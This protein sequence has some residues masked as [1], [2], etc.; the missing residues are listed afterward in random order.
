MTSLTHTGSVPARLTLAAGRSH[1]AE[2]ILHAWLEGK[3]DHTVRNYRHD[4]EDFALYLSRALAIEP[5][6]NVGEALTRLFGQ[7]SPSAHEIG[8]GFRSH[9]QAARLSAASI[10]RHLAT[11]RSVSKLARM[12][13]TVNGGWFLEVL[14][15]KAERR[16]DT[17]GPDVADIR[18]MLEATGGD[19]EG[20]TRD[21]AMVM[22]FYCLGLRVSELCGLTLM[23]TDLARGTTWIKAKGRREKELVPLPAAVVDALKR[24]LRWRGMQ[25]GPLFQTRGQRG[26]RR[27]G[28]LETRSVLRIVR[29]LGQR[30]GLHVWCHSLR[31]T[32][33]TQAAELGQKA[34]IGLDKIRAHSRHRTIAT[35]MLYVDEHDRQRTQ[36]TLADLVA[37]TLTA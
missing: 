29:E 16:R 13:G 9:L 4:L 23:E 12:L 6:L 26:K 37:G 18:R 17:R 5:I 24:Y 31:H 35:L 15:V 7:S 30:V 20:E 36:T 8:L 33:I 3:S 10:N 22:V 19:T 21:Y 1:S 27:D 2:T 28:R 34:G 11:L 25:P 14:G 32:S